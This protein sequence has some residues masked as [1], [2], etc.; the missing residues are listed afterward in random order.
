MGVKGWEK[1]LSQIED[2]LSKHARVNLGLERDHMRRIGGAS[3]PCRRS[4]DCYKR[5]EGGSEDEYAGCFAL[6]V[7]VWFNR[8]RMSWGRPVFPHGAMDWSQCYRLGERCA[9]R[10]AGGV[11][12]H[13]ALGP[14]SRDEEDCW[15]SILGG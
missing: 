3:W 1:E 10:G 7:P 8:V 11:C 9:F 2:G 15:P 14:F 5:I 13:V 6:V 12:T 4:G